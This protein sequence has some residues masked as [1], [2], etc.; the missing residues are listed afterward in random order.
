[1]TF[2]RLTFFSPFFFS[3]RYPDEFGAHQGTLESP[4]AYRRAMAATIEA[5]ESVAESTG[6]HN[7]GSSEPPSMAY[8]PDISA[9]LR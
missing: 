9:T 4:D 6:G 5:A 1:M 2:F 7:V 8:A 3:S